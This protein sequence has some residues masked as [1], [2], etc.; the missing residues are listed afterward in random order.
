[1]LGCEEIH[2][3]W[4]IRKYLIMLTEKEITEIAAEYANINKTE[5]YYLEYLCAKPSVFLDGYWD[6]G[7][8]VFTYKGNEPK[9]PLLIAIDG[10]NGEINTMEQLIMKHSRDS[11]VKISNQ[12]IKKR[13]N[14]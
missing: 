12:P 6:A 3:N 11:R 13:N 14:N 5:H 2:A 4:C 7:F 9:G 8:T 1:M 10:E